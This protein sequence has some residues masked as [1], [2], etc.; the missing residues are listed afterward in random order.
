MLFAIAALLAPL[1]LPGGSVDLVLGPPAQVAAPGST[2]DVTLTASSATP[3]TLSAID[4]ILSWDPA[5][6]E[7]L[8][9]DA[10]SY[11]WFVTGF[12]PDPGGINLDTTDG[13]ALFTML[14]SL[15]VPA[16]VPPDILAVTFQFKVLA[17]GSVS[18]KPTSGV[19]ATRVLS[20]VIGQEIT[21]DISAVAAV[22]AGPVSYCTAGT[23]GIGCQV[24]L[25]ATG[26]ASAS[27]SSGFVVSGDGIEGG[28]KGTYFYGSNGRQAMPWGNGS[29]FRCVLPPTKRVGVQSATGA[30]GSCGGTMTRDLNAFWCPTC[31]KPNKNPG[32]GSVVQLQLWYRDAQSTSNQKTSF[33]DA[34]E[35]TVSP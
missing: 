34:L 15:A 9:A 1:S 14:A 18:L 20:T 3:E 31:P 6:L 16:A 35:F 5:E 30:P 24:L 23:S 11:P 13:E 8:G 19:S 27:A 25:S 32:A 2:I 7:L 26:S 12:L 4:A 33:S 29:S 21:G 28:V 22:N 10:S 17:S